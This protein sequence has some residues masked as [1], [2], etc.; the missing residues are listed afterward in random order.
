MLIFYSYTMVVRQWFHKNV[1][2]DN[3]NTV[4]SPQFASG[5]VYMAISV[6]NKFVTMLVSLERTG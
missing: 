4:L 1:I 2:L 6:A 5:R 3:T